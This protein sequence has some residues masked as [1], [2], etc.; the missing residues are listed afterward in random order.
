MGTAG[1]GAPVVS[2][3]EDGA[4]VGLSLAALFAPL[5][6][7]MALILLAWVLIAGA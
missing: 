1:F 5:L 2:T 7:L 4:S 3:A 6:C